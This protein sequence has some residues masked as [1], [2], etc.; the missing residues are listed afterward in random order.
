LRVDDQERGSNFFDSHFSSLRSISGS[1]QS[2][3]RN[4]WARAP[5]FL[6]PSLRVGQLPLWHSRA[7]L[8]ARKSHVRGFLSDTIDQ[9]RTIRGTRSRPRLTHHHYSCTSSHS[10]AAISPRS[11]RPLPTCLCDGPRRVC[12]P[13]LERRTTVDIS[14]QPAFQLWIQSPG[15]SLSLSQRRTRS[16]RSLTPFRNS[17][18]GTLSKA[19]DLRRERPVSA[20][21]S[22]SPTPTGHRTVGAPAVVK[23]SLVP[24]ECTLPPLQ[25]EPNLPASAESVTAI[26]RFP[27]PFRRLATESHPLRRFDVSTWRL[28]RL[29]KLEREPTA[30]PTETQKDHAFAADEAP[31][32]LRH[33]RQPRV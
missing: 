1:V 28:E 13:N 8:S 5:S 2:H 27:S 14:G 10:S 29:D 12:E 16:T 20:L 33:Y 4:F 31:R 23:E 9:L 30:L 19:T 3:R 32:S 22:P 17:H 25:G 11:C 7:Y 6:S 24:S 26:L 18:F 21:P 15:E